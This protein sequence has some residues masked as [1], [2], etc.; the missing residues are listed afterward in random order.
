MQCGLTNDAEIPLAQLLMVWR[1]NGFVARQTGQIGTLPV[2][3]IRPHGATV[4]MGQSVRL[5]FVCCT[6]RSGDVWS[7]GTVVVGGEEWS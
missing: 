5:I 2:V 4:L 3:S 6:V 7:G 1:Q